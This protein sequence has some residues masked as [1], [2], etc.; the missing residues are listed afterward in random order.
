[1]NANASEFLPEPPE[2]II[3]DMSELEPTRVLADDGFD[4]LEEEA[5]IELAR[6]LIV[7]RSARSVR[8]GTRRYDKKR[9][10]AY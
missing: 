3:I 10:P 9:R 5:S 6:D 1:M 7:A 2:L 8:Q 4:E